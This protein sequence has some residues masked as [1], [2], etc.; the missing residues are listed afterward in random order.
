MDYLNYKNICKGKA[1]KSNF[2]L[3]HLPLPKLFVNSDME[4]LEFGFFLLS[5]FWEAILVND[6]G[7][8]EHSKIGD[9]R[10]I[11]G[12]VLSTT[13]LLRLLPEKDEYP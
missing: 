13:I 9:A 4:K 5:V 6:E 7:Q 1:R 2:S 11:K 12:P 8:M 3:S 10:K